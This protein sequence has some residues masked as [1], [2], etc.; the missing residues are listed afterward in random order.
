MPKG[1]GREGSSLSKGGRKA[2]HSERCSSG[3]VPSATGGAG[4]R[5]NADTRSKLVAVASAGRCDAS[6][7]QPNS[8]SFVD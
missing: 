3:G 6:S 5:G 4:E 2:K 8:L 7:H 1:V